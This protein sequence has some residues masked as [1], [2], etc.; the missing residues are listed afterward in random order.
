M[1]EELKRLHQA[2]DD[3]EQKNIHLIGDN[4]RLNK[5]YEETDSHNQILEG[6]HHKLR[7]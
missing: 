1:E 2:N 4:D 5:L 3:L 7:I 6:E